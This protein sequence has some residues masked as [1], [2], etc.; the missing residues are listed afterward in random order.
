MQNMTENL[1]KSILDEFGEKKTLFVGQ[2]VRANTI[3]LR[4][5]DSVKSLQTA[6]Y[7]IR[8]FSENSCRTLGT[9][10]PHDASDTTAPQ[11]V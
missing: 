7:R 2:D 6:I 3:A 1:H 9:Y 5:K 11:Q 4:H 10:I 8:I